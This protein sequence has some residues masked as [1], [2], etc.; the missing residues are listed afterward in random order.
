LRRVT[1]CMPYFD[2][3]SMLERQAEVFRDY[4][5]NWPV[6]WIV[7]DDCSPRWPATPKEVGFP[8]ELFRIT[9]PIRW[10]QDV[11]RNAAAH[12]APDGCWLLLTDI[13]HLI[14]AETMQRVLFEPL[15]KGMIYKFSRVSAPAMSEYKVHPNSW[16]LTK[17]CYWRLGGYDERFAGWYGTDSDFRDRVQAYLGGEAEVLPEHL[18]RVPREVI[19]DA[20]TPLLDGN[21]QPTRKT[22]ADAINIRRIKKERAKLEDQ[23]PITLSFDYVRVA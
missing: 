18:I 1:V 7:V 5:K 21:G 9:V 4:P 12:E 19:P 11:A 23:T 6:R 15:D 2:N 16:C 13:D 22:E 8:M 20:S 10:G 3:P 17:S 14:P